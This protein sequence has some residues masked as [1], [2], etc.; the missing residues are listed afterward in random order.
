MIQTFLSDKKNGKQVL[1]YNL[2]KPFFVRNGFENMLPWCDKH[3]SIL[4]SA[5]DHNCNSKKDE[6]LKFVQ[7][8]M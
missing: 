2:V 8:E 7:N 1:P 5:H 6:R 3:G 4:R